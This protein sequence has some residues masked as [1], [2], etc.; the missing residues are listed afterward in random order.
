[1]GQQRYS[2][3]CNMELLH[4]NIW[5]YP[6]EL[7]NHFKVVLAEREQYLCFHS[8]A[9]KPPFR[10]LKDINISCLQAKVIVDRCD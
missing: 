8:V 6:M 7:C 3:S 9:T 4:F 10:L 2:V 5:I 1:M